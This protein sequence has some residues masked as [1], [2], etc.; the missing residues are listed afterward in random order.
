MIRQSFGLALAVALTVTGGLAACGSS[1]PDDG[2]NAPGGGGGG[3]A[4]AGGVGGGAGGSG[5]G[6]PSAGASG[7][8]GAAGAAAVRIPTTIPEVQ[9]FLAARS[10]L[11]QNNGKTWQCG[12]LGQIAAPLSPHTD[13]DGTAQARICATNSVVDDDNFVEEGPNKGWPVGIAAVKE[14]YD[15]NN[16]ELLT[17]Y[18]YYTKTRD[19]WFW[20]EGD[21]KRPVESESGGPLAGLSIDECQ[22]CHQNGDQEFVQK[23][24]KIDENDGGGF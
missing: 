20:Y 14:I 24:N 10:Y 11:P 1:D 2:V 12:E 16:P 5:P 13:V 15:N 21:L 22:S 17:R 6:T 7:G 3:A 18:A 23:A 9:A 8:N 19:A 4:G